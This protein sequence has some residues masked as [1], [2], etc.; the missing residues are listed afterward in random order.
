MNTIALLTD[1]GSRDNFVGTVKGVIL[2]NNPR[3]ILIDISHNIFSYDIKGAAFILLSCFS[4]FPKRTVFLAAV[5]PGVGSKQKAI[6][7]KTRN[8]YFV[9]PDNGILSLAAGR[10]GVEKIVNLKNKKYFLKEVSS[11]FRARDIFA[12]CAA[13]LSMGLS[14]DKLGGNLTKIEKTDFGFSKITKNEIQAEIIYADKFG[15]LFTNI[16]CRQFAS[17]YKQ[18]KNFS[19]VL[20]KKIIDKIYSFYNEAKSNEPFFIEGSSQ[21]LEIALKN[22][23]AKDFF[24]VK[25]MNQK[26][27]IKNK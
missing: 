16:T 11:T 26:L 25:K 13:Y 24:S 5:D 19:A 1:F 17:F 15:N 3:A 21:F 4:Y 7:I 8:Y 10:D 12:P 20:N 2:N 22:K 27:V 9:G 18:N 23:S 14:I 6:A